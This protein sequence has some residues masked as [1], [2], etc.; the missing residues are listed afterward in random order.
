MR[1]IVAVY[2]EQRR[3]MPVGHSKLKVCLYVVVVF[4]LCSPRYDEGRR[5]RTSA[6][7]GNINIRVFSYIQLAVSL[8]L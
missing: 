4:M 3:E 7:G 2:R 1:W 5:R 8:S 6:D